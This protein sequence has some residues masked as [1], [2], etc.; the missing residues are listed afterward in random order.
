MHIRLTIKENDENMKKRHNRHRLDIDINEKTSF[1]IVHASGSIDASNIK[2]FELAIEQQCEV[3][4]PKIILNCT[5]L[6]YINSTGFDL[7]FHF[8][9]LCTAG[10]GRFVMCGVSSKITSILEL[11]GL[12]KALRIYKT[13]N[14]AIEDIQAQAQQDVS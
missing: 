1:S 4:A 2:Q 6:T 3:E 12:T 10:G 5:N 8:H 11:L 7:L 13:E 9:K 14:E